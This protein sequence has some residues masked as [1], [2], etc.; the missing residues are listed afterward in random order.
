MASWIAGSSPAMT[1]EC[2]APPRR[3]VRNSVQPEL[4]VDRLQLSRLDQPGVGD[5]NR[6]QRAFQLLHPER[7]KALQL[8]KFREQVVVLPDERLQKPLVVGPAVENLR[9]GQAITG[10]LPLEV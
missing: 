7:E 4:A 2:G 10:H 8:G 6:M 3:T 1:A 5:Q 9:G